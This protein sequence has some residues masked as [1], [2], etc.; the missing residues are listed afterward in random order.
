MESILHVFGDA[1]AL[2]T[3]HSVSIVY[4]D[5]YRAHRHET[6][7]AVLMMIRISCFALPDSEGGRFPRVLM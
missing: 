3:Y 7:L 1:A 6:R 5:M 2:L 4:G